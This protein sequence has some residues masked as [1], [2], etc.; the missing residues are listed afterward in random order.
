MKKSILLLAAALC[1]PHLHAENMLKNG[2]FQ[3]GTTGWKGD[4]KVLEEAAGS[5]NKIARVEAGRKPQSFSQTIDIKKE[6]TLVLTFRVRKSADYAGLGYSVRFKR[7]D[8][9]YTFFERVV[10]E[11]DGWQEVTIRFLDLQDS[12]KIEL[13]VVVLPGEKGYLEFDDFAVEGK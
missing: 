12:R 2:D 1:A 4:R 13:S 11:E 7:R 10:D 8:N 9:S 5:K 3:G 6:K